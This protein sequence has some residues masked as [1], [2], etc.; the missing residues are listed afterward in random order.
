MLGLVHDRALD[1]LES[2]AARW[3]GRALR[4][5]VGQDRVTPYFFRP[6][7]TRSR[8]AGP[9][10]GRGARRGRQLCYDTM[11]LVRAGDLGGGARGG[12]LRAHRRRARDG[13][14][15]RR[16]RAG[17]A[18]PVP[19]AGASR[20]PQR[21]RRVVLPQQ[22][23]G[24]G[25]GAARRGTRAGRDPRPRR[26]PRQRHPGHL[27]G[28]LRRPVQV[29]TSTR[30]ASWF[31]HVFGY[32]DEAGEACRRQGDAQ[33]LPPGAGDDGW[34]EAVVDLTTW[35]DLK[36]CT[37]LVVSLG[38]DAAA[39]TRALQV[40]MRTATPGRGAHRGAVAADRRRA[41][42][43]LHLPTLEE[44]V[45]SFLD[46]HAGA[47]DLAPLEHLFDHGLA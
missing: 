4:A 33:P 13:W 25:R 2:A 12:R 39:A 27:L 46:G 19:S 21:V 38:V 3:A 24:R 10:G 14:R 42:G 5:E 41:G 29:G 8:D 6:A 20:H 17:G 31:P 35:L 32:A 36:G 11:T 23:G 22:R 30:G 45:A 18:R 37:A 28:P 43:G 9:P 7:L 40:S 26:A 34:L 47:S 44:L 16:G 1:W 15:A